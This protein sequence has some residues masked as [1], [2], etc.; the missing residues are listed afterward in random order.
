MSSLTASLNQHLGA[1]R[2]HW[3]RHRAFPSMEQLAAVLGVKSG[4]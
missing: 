4:W 3:R 2:L 1:L